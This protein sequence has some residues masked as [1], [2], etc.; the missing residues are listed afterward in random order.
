MSTS[1]RALLLPGRAYP[2][3]MPLLHFT[4][5]ALA[6]HG[7]S[8]RAVSWELPADLPDV[9]R[10]VADQA[11]AAIATEPPAERWLFAAK[12]LGTRIVHAAADGPRADAYVLLTPLLDEPDSV[13]AIATLV[14]DGVPVLLVGGTG[15]QFW[16]TE[17]ARAT[18]ARVLEVPDA[19]HAM[20]VAGDAVR[21]AEIHLDVTR[22]VDA[23]LASL[24]Q[25]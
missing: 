20:A 12:S 19:D 22:A 2:A 16:S 11:A 14:S 1:R 25:L 15:D 10:W 17:G 3:T 6:Q 8:P 5:L 13:D 23:F 21:T 24:P 9:N 18:G 4:G 7:W